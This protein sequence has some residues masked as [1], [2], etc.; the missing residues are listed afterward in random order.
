MIDAGAQSIRA[1][2]VHARIAAL[3]REARPIGAAVIVDDALRV[4]A[5]GGAAVRH[6]ADAVRAARRR[7]AR[8]DGTGGRL[9]GAERIADHVRRTRAHRTVV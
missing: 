2:R 1:A 6:T 4:R 7:I 8:I 5:D 9:T 3:L